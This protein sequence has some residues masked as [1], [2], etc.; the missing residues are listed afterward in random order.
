MK[1]PLLIALLAAGLLVCS[2]LGCENL[3]RE[4]KKNLIGILSPAK[5]NAE[6]VRGFIEG[7]RERGYAEGRNVAFEVFVGRGGDAIDADLQSLLGRELDLLFTVTTPAT[8]KAQKK[9]AARKVPLVFALFDP[10]ASGVIESRARPGGN[11]TGIQFRGSVPKALEWFLALAPGVKNLWIPIR[12]DTI[13]ARQSL[14]D[15]RKAA[16]A[17][18][19]NLIV[20]E[21]EGQEDLDH[22]LAAPP[23]ECEGIFLLNSILISKNIRKIVPMAIQ[24]KLPL[25]GATAQYMNGVLVSYGMNTFEAGKQASRIADQILKGGQ[26]GDIPTEVAKYSLGINLPTARALGLEVADEV[27][28][29]ADYIVR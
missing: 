16:R 20:Q 23:E 10:V 6:I 2:L 13:A 9:L 24:R 25:G 3:T 12:F 26:A 29:Q 28:R 1:Q 14:G 15:L 18:D 5:G 21:V 8:K 27:L 11:A 17:L 19:V 7:L 4:E 22:A